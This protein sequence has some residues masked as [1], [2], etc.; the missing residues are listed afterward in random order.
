M[1][2]LS[3]PRSPTQWLILNALL[4]GAQTTP[5]LQIQCGTTHAPS[6]IHDL[7]ARGLTIPCSLIPVRNRHGAEVKTGLYSLTDA[8]RK[9]VRAWMKAK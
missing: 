5:T 8:D 4:R 7:R 6:A 1:S 2:A 9:I 3:A